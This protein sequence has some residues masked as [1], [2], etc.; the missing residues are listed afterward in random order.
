M[1]TFMAVYRV[2][3]YVSF[4]DDLQSVGQEAIIY[5]TAVR[6]V[7]RESLQLTI[8]RSRKENLTPEPIKDAQKFALHAIKLN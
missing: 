5:N 2:L 8:K 6:F 4:F 7:Q 1:R 3:L